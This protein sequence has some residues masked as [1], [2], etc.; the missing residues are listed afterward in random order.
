MQ[1]RTTVTID[2]AEIR[3]A[4]IALGTSGIQDTV[5]RA[6]REVIRTHRRHR[7]AAA[8]R[9]GTAFDF[10]GAALDREDHWQAS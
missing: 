4:Q 10:D 3:E 2:D 5:E 7:F 1:R 9:A 8:V 6:L